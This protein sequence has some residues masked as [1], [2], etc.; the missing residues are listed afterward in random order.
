MIEK[1]YAVILLNYNTAEDAVI[2]ASSIVNNAISDDYL[3]CFIDGCSTKPNQTDIF[4]A[5][6]IHN[7]VVL[8]LNENIGYARGNNAGIKY[9]LEKY[10]VFHFVI[11]NPDVEIKTKG[12]ID[13]LIDCLSELD[14]SYCGI[15][16]L[17][18]TPSIC[19]DSRKQTCIRKVYSYFDCIMD[20]FFPIRKLFIKKYHKIIYYKERPYK[21]LIDFEVPSGCFFI[22][23]A[24]VFYR[25]GLFDERTFLFAEEIILGYKLKQKGYKF[26]LN[27]K[28]EVIHEGGKS[29]GSHEIISRFVAKEEIKSLEMYLRYYL[30]CGVFKR[31]FVK[32]LFMLNY[33]CKKC[34]CLDRLQI[35]S[36]INYNRKI[37]TK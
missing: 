35:K 7:T 23:K 6:N 22:I 32:A 11:M 16:P 34:V 9:L 1:K 37:N 36:I 12:L 17:V 28:Y 2:A 4:K 3:I 31:K 26:I 20:S 18:W 33:F 29:T 15:Q 30:N 21:Q 25:V 13:N 5:A 27:P 19:N 14:T 24:D 8:E 10:N